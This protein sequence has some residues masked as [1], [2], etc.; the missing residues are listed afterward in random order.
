VRYTIDPDRSTVWIRARSTLHP[1][2]AEMTGLEGFFEADVTPEGALDLS[3]A[4]RGHLEFAVDRLA[5]NN[6]VFDVELK[7][8]IDARR[9]PV[10][11][12]D[13]V[14]MRPGSGPERYATDGEVTFRGVTRPAADELALSLPEPGAVVL[15]GEHVFDVE[16]FEMRAPRI[17]LVRVYPDVRVRVRIVASAS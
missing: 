3:V 10:I 4:P 7:R 16:T 6:P 17:L 14:S 9:Y 8:R 2:S 5:S 11:T 1:I 13:L 12:G 15:E